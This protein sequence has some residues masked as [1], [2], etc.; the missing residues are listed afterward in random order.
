MTRM[1]DVVAAN[2]KAWFQA[3]FPGKEDRIRA[4]SPAGGRRVSARWC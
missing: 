4:L 1:E 3:Y 2:P